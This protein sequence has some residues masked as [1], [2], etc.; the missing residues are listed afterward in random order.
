MYKKGC[1]NFVYGID[2]MFC[3]SSY[4]QSRSRQHH[5]EK[6]YNIHDNNISE[7]DI[8][9]INPFS[10]IDIDLFVKRFNE[11]NNTNINLWRHLE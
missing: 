8:K 1:I 6:V 11:K 4:F 5:L 3:L 2:G 10:N 9:I 7:N